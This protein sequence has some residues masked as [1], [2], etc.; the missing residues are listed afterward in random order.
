MVKDHLEDA[1][2][3]GI[4]LLRS[5]R[6]AGPNSPLLSDKKYFTEYANDSKYH[7]F[8]NKN[9]KISRE[10]EAMGFGIKTLKS[11]G[12]ANRTNNNHG[13]LKGLSNLSSSDEQNVPE[14]VA[15]WADTDAVATSIAHEVSFFCTNDVAKGTTGKGV[16]S[17]MSPINSAI[18]TAKYGL[19]FVTP[20]QFLGRI[21]C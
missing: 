8:N 19:E 4:R 2:G 15:E 10:L 14:L 5:K 21:R 1:Y 20:Q 3:I 11:L 12:E 17:I 7:E 9:G 16:N 6:I 18:I 13:W